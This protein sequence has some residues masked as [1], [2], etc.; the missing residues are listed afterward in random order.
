M[1]KR[2][3][4]WLLSKIVGEE[5]VIM[6]CR[7][8]DYDIQRNILPEKNFGISYQNKITNIVSLIEEEMYAGSPGKK[9]IR[10]GNSF[11]L[12]IDNARR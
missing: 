2:F 3:K 11:V 6:N 9:V 10:K 8:L 1:W 7:I 5:P 4:V 12:T